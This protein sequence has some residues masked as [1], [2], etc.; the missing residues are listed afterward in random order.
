AAARAARQTG[1]AIT[2]HS[3]MSDVGL[4]QL[5]VFEAEGADP[6]RV[7]VGHADSFPSM[8][9]H[10]AVIERG[11]NLEFDFLGMQFTPL[12]RFGEPRLIGLICDLVERGHGD[13]VLLSQDVCHNSQLRIYEGSG[14]TYL[15]KTFLPRLR[16]AGVTAATIEQM[17]VATPRRLLSLGGS[18]GAA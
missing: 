10:L 15:M 17:T 11:A 13:R 16:E 8:A 2:T 9:Y 3:V 7:I 6:G 1:M 14:Y 12:E 5:E 18:G 4:R